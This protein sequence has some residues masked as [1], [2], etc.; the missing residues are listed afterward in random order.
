V[1]VAVVG[2][3]TASL[4]L[5]GAIGALHL[6]AEL[7]LLDSLPPRAQARALARARIA[8]L[9]A[10][11]VQARLLVEAGLAAPALRHVVLGGARLDGAARA[12]LQAAC[13]GAWIHEFYG[14]AEAS[15]IAIS[16]PDTPPGA[17]GRP[18]PGVTL[19][20]G[21]APGRIRLRSP[22]LALGYTGGD[23]GGAV[24][25]DGWLTLPELGRMQDGHLVLLGRADRMVTVADTNVFPEAVEAVLLAQPG[26]RQAAVIPQADG[27]RGHVLVALWQGP[28]GADALR[29]ACRAALPPPAVPR[30][31]VPV[32]D[33]PLLAA[34]KTDLAA[35]GRRL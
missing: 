21:A 30:R 15:F 27:R 12:A 3:L 19:D 16:G 17:V 28:A 14:A 9:W 8:H 33:W 24:W 1:G 22:Y 6:G 13:P 2:G 7:H 35:L 32:A 10:T 5:Y 26:V 31:F 4:A 23:P 25:A 20:L 34:G 18:Y 11:P 29:A